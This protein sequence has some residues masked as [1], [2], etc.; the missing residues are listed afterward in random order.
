[1][2]SSIKLNRNCEMLN[3]VEHRSTN[4]V[5]SDEEE[6]TYTYDLQWTPEF[7]ESHGYVES[8]HDNNN[9][10]WVF[11]KLELTANRVEVGM[12]LLSDSQ[13]KQC[14]KTD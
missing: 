9:M 3:W 13:K 2:N 8:G 12:F 6:V 14:I 1:M 5:S 4:R 7:H 11:D 10:D